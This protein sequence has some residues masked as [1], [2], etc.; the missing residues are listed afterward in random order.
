M[1]RIA[2]FLEIASYFNGIVQVN[3]EYV[4]STNWPSR[5][6]SS[7]SANGTDIATESENENESEEPFNPSEGSSKSTEPIETV[8]S[9]EKPKSY[10]CCAGIR[11]IHA[12]DCKWYKSDIQGE[13]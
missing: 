7:N 2:Y 10:G 3:L 1:K 8:D 12:R 13:Q 9:D 11:P 4:K 6:I 5:N